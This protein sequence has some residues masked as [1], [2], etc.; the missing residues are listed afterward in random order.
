MRVREESKRGWGHSV[1][2]FD[3]K[4]LSNQMKQLDH[5]HKNPYVENIA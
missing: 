3:P 1:N 2:S 5:L 4:T